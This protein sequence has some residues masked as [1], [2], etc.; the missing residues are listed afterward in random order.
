MEICSGGRGESSH[1]DIV[2]EDRHCPFC[3]YIKDKEGEIAGLKDEIENLKSDIE[4]LE[5]SE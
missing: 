3:D 1:A 2:Y 5:A 4:R